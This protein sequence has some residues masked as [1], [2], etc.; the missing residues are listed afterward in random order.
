MGKPVKHRAKLRRSS[1]GS[2]FQKQSFIGNGSK[3]LTTARDTGDQEV[4]KSETK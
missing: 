1:S 2:I 3:K 4:N